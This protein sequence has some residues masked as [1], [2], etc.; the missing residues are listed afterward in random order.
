MTIINKQFPRHEIW[1]GGGLENPSY[2]QLVGSWKHFNPKVGY[3]QTCYILRGNEIQEFINDL[4]TEEII[5]NRIIEE[6]KRIWP[7][8]WI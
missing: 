4:L 2:I 1:Y 5:N 3:H 7:H 8:L 6:S